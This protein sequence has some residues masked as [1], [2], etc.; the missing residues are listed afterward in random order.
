M[1]V[2]PQFSKPGLFKK[3]EFSSSAKTKECKSQS[4]KFNR[5]FYKIYEWKRKEKVNFLHISIHS[6]QLHGEFL[7]PRVTK[8][9]KFSS[10]LS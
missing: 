4:W 8:K 9:I 5:Q 10:F 3:E 2:G 6:S 1:G 7:K